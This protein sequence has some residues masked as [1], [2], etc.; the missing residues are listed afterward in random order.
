MNLQHRGM[1][2]DTR[3]VICRRL[4]EDGA[5]LF[6]KCKTIAHVWG[7]LGLERERTMLAEKNS[8]RDAIEAV[9]VMKEEKQLKNSS[10][11]AHGIQ[12]Y[13][14]NWCSK[15]SNEKRA[16][17]V[18]SQVWERPPEDHAK[19]NCDASFDSNSGLGGWGCILRDSD[20]EAIE[21]RRGKLEALL[22]PMQGEIIACIQGIQAAAEAGVGNVIIE[23]DA[24]TVV[25]AVYSSAYDL[26]TVTYLVAEL[27]SLLSLNFLSWRV[28]YRSRSCNRVAHELA[29]L[30]SLSSL[31][32]EPVLVPIPCHI[33]SVIADNSALFE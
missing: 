18:V 5:H 30:G 32:V 7:I 25:Q 24:S 23:M 9:L 33:Q 11:L 26:S 28:Q 14:A 17:P 13:A 31:D 20:G 3:C 27:R 15:G 2:L 29:A 12:V 19:V 21:A 8:A 1:K 16:T 4:K 6:F 10:R 22:D